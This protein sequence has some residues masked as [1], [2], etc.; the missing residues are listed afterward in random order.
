MTVSIRCC[1]RNAN[2]FHLELHDN[3]IEHSEILEIFALNLLPLK[4]L[5]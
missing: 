1:E 5:L 4:F 2:G 3:L